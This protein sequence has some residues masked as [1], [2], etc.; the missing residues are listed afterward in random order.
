METK[1]VIKIIQSLADGV[2]PFNGEKF[3]ENSPYQNPQLVRALYKSVEALEY[4]KIREGKKIVLP[5]NAG[6]PWAEI[7]D[8][9]LINKFDAGKSFDELANEHQRT[10]GAIKSRLVKLGKIKEVGAK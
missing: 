5:K 2:N 6:N 7:E 10:V 1:D 4:L 3:P 8:K 9:A